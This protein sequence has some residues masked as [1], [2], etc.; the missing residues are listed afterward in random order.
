LTLE[1]SYSH[2]GLHTPVNNP[3]EQVLGSPKESIT[4][5][6]FDSPLFPLLSF[7][8][9]QQR[10]VCCLINEYDDDDGD[11]DILFRSRLRWMPM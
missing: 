7:L 2:S 11:D 10:S 5:R 3:F 1:D 6:Q 9:A 8:T 4:Y